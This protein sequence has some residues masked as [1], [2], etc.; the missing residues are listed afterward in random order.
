MEDNVKKLFSN[1]Q[2]VQGDPQAMNS[3]QPTRTVEEDW[4]VTRAA[5][6]EANEKR[7]WMEAF[8]LLTYLSNIDSHPEAYAAM[9]QRAWLAL[10]VEIPSPDVA[11]TLYNLLVSLGPRHAAAGAIASLANFLAHRRSAGDQARELAIAQAGHMLRYVAEVN[12]LEPGEP[13]QAWVKA[14]HLDD[15]EHF[16]P[17]VFDVIEAL[18]RGKWWIDRDAV[19]EELENWSRTQKPPAR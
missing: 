5:L 19:Q 15:P 8:H 14:N 4:N 10:K 12:N 17:M 13:F 16:V 18:A 2:V 7:D 11:L 3:N 1:I 9:A 6:A